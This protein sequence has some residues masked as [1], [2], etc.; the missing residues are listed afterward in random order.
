MTET[1]VPFRDL[2]AKKAA[3]PEA[4]STEAI[5]QILKAMEGMQ[6]QIASLTDLVVAMDHRLDKLEG[7]GKSK[8]IQ[9]RN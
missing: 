3:E 4:G 9:V 1:I 7:K 6:E 5:E 8:L 2:A